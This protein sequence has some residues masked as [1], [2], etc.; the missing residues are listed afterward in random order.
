MVIYNLFSLML[1]IL[2]RFHVLNCA[3]D[4]AFIFADDANKVVFV[5]LLP[6]AKRRHRLEI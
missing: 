3:H 6:E 4:R 2:A 5:A 1:R